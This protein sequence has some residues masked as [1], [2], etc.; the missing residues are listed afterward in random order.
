[1]TN[2]NELLKYT[3]STPMPSDF[4][5]YWDDAIIEMKSIDPNVELIKVLDLPTVECFD[6]Y[7]TGV[8]GARIHAK[9]AKPKNITKPTG[10]MLYFH[11]YHANF[12]E[13]YRLLVF[14]GQ[15]LCVAAMDCRGQAGKSEDKGGVIGNTVIGHIIR[16]MLENDPKK[17]LYRSIYLDTAQLANI[18]MNFDF[19]DE[20]RVYSFGGS[21]GAGLALACAALEPKIKKTVA[22]CPFLCDFKKAYELN[23][24][25]FSE[26]QD[27]FVRTDPRHETEEYVFN[28]IAYVDVSNLAHRIK[29]KVK[30]LTGMRDATCPPITQFAMYN[31]LKSEK[32]YYIYPDYAH[33]D[34]PE[35][36]DIALKWFVEE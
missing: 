35:V 20:N 31:K 25:A 12:P 15:G 8:G 3:G 2:I 22:Y 28:R 24:G 11:G 7:F 23:G 16:G 19:V 14:A 21:Q 9:F 1:M 5:S 30:M 18:V 34:Y 27:Y 13:W 29:A 10:A 33:A 17:L 26:I 6:M 4:D 36:F 32:E